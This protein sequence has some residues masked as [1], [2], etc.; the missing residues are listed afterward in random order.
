MRVHRRI[1]AKTETGPIPHA[2]WLAP[3]FSQGSVTPGNGAGA[4]QRMP[5]APIPVAKKTPKTTVKPHPSLKELALPLFPGS[6]DTGR[7]MT[8]RLTSIGIPMPVESSN[9]GL[10][11]S[12]CPY[13][14]GL[15]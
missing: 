10:L 5:P 1:R 14:V 6:A 2:A 15:S 13:C 4:K 3:S 9:L 11:R 8:C 7:S 12:P